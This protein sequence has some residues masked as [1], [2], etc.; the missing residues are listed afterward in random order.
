MNILEYLTDAPVQK[1]A[2]LGKCFS[3]F[4][5]VIVNVGND[6]I[7]KQGQTGFLGSI[8]ELLNSF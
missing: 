5:H 3:D 6:N 2:S 8:M 7:C 1:R 4:F